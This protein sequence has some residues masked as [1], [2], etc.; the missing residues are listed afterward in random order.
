MLG[1]CLFCEVFTSEDSCFCCGGNLLYGIPAHPTA[2][3]VYRSTALSALVGGTI[4]LA[5]P[6]PASLI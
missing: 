1:Y 4:V 6:E 5:D 2:S 3:H